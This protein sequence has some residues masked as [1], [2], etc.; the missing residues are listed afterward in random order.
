MLPRRQ[1]LILARWRWRKSETR[2]PP[3]PRLPSPPKVRFLLHRVCTFPQNKMRAKK[4]V[5]RISQR[6]R[7]MAASVFVCVREICISRECVPRE[8]KAI[9]RLMPGRTIKAILS[10]TTLVILI[11][12]RRRRMPSAAVRIAHTHTEQS[13]RRSPVSHLRG[14][15]LLVGRRPNQYSQRSVSA[16]YTYKSTMSASVYR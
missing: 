6:V 4:W 1:T 13:T 10:R 7:V 15:L 12:N 11:A 2:E 14:T 3:P 16:T 9:A 5:S 8:L